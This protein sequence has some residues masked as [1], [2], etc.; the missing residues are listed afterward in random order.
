LL[1]VVAALDSEIV[2]G[3][4][5]PVLGVLLASVNAWQW[6]VYRKTA[7]KAGIP[8]LARASLARIT[9]WLHAIGHALPGLLYVTALTMIGEE[10]IAVLAVA[11]IASLAGG[12][13]WKYTV[14]VLAS[15]QQGF[16]LPR[17]PRRGSGD[18]TAP[19]LCGTL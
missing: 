9:P 4:V 19:G 7:K 3:P 12:A 14:V 18:R 16:A 6:W 5:G 11:G 13:I 2:I 8:P 1:F 17:L 10:Q 15:Y